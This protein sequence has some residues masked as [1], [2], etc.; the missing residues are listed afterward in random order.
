M[1]AT[2]ITIL[3]YVLD[4]QSAGQSY[5]NRY[6]MLEHRLTTE[7]K[8]QKK[9]IRKIVSNL[10]LSDF[11]QQ[12]STSLLFIT[13]AGKE[14][15]HNYHRLY[16]LPPLYKKITNTIKEYAIVISVISLIF[17]AYKIIPKIEHLVHIGISLL[18]RF[19]N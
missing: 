5:F 9:D 8:Y 14:Y 17:N 4:H 16:S 6:F 12:T 7:L 11:I 13:E 1:M 15:L 10:C 19:Y 2:P 18:K 3:Q